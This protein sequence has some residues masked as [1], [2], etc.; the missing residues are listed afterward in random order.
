MQMNKNKLKS[1]VFWI[2]GLSGSGKTAIAKMFNSY[3]KKK[4]TK[5]IWLDG[6][7]LRKKLKLFHNK[8][9]FSFNFRIKLGKKYSRIA[10]SYE[11]KGFFV[12]MS[13]M[14]LSKEVFKFNRRH[15]KNYHEIYLNV[16]LSELKTR[17]PK[18]IYKNF[19]LGKIKNVAG[20]DIEFEKPKKPS[21]VVNW[22]KGISKIEVLK[23]LKNY[24]YKYN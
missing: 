5:I 14:A 24:F 15:I 20:L 4:Y 8:N 10:R 23:K 3:L 11:K 2:T 1:G 12:I 7:Q 21:L 22:K 9:T 13:V 18:K 17:D 16:P 6:D 19:Q